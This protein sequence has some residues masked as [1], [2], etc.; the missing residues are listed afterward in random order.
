MTGDK[1]Q[2]N[3]QPSFWVEC[4]ICGL[5]FGIEGRPRTEDLRCEMCGGDNEI[6][7]YE[8]A[9]EGTNEEG[10]HNVTWRKRSKYHAQNSKDNQD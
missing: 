3:W 10:L 1:Q 5:S 2:M 6:T 4:Y 9:H 8:L 7:L